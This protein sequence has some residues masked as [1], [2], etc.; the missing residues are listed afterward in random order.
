MANVTEPP[1][2]D[3]AGTSEE[4]WQAFFELCTVVTW[5]PGR[6]RS[7]RAVVVAPHPDDEI[8]GPGGTLSVL[9][10]AGTAIVLVAV[11][12]GE[13]SHLG[14]VDELRALR[15]RE[16]AQA[17]AVLGIT[18]SSI[19]RL[20][21]PDGAIDED[22]LQ[23]QLTDLVRAGDLL[24]AP[25][26]RDGHPDHDRAGRAAL[27]V[28]LH[29]QADLL[30]YLVWTWQW[31][32]PSTDLPWSQA[33]RVELGGDLAGRKRRATE[34]FRSQITGADPVLPS[35]VLRKLTRPFEVFLRP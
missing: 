33:S 21:H 2:L 28:G 34:C 22:R 4:V 7:G 30:F 25:W 9:S 24:L 8:L 13:A 14:R 35:H 29:Q 1:P 31:A 16:S 20:G 23:Q 27:R 15:P 11:T 32:S 6:P 5:T 17:A 18:P 3:G 10:T 19:H 12:D 26:W